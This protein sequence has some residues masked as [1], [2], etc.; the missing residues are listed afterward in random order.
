VEGVEVLIINLFVVVIEVDHPISRL[1]DHFAFLSA[2]TAEG[3]TDSVTLDLRWQQ[4]EVPNRRTKSFG[5]AASATGVAAPS[6]TPGG[7]SSLLRGKART[8]SRLPIPAGCPPVL[9][10]G[11]R[12]WRDSPDEERRIQEA[13]AR[14]GRQVDRARA[15][16]RGTMRRRRSE[17]AC[18]R[19]TDAFGICS[20]RAKLDAA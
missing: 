9:L 7:Y 15:A 8:G 19:R 17:S 1:P 18:T 16:R 14:P 20:L 2:A 4:R 11:N 5:V 10:N 13:R 6:E 3:A 12:M